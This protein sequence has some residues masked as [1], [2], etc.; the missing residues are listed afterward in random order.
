VYLYGVACGFFPSRAQVRNRKVPGID[1]NEVVTH[2]GIS[3][4]VPSEKIIEI[5]DG[6]ELKNK[7]QK[8]I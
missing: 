6:S 8:R 2:Y 4:V 5:L 1:V 7:R 3:T